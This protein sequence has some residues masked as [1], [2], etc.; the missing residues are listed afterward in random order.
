ML[1]QP[2]LDPGTEVQAMGRVHRIGQTRVTVVHRFVI[3]E[4]IEEKVSQ[5]F[6]KRIESMSNRVPGRNKG[7]SSSSQDMRVSEIAALLHEDES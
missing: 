6:A 2:L 3:S 7:K 1:M 4:S 5:V